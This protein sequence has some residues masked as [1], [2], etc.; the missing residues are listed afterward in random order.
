VRVLVGG[1]GEIQVLYS[2]GWIG[3]KG[4]GEDGLF[5]YI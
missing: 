5:Y 4:G 3:I 2:Y 1:M